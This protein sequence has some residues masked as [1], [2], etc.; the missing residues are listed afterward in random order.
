MKDY[1]VL[2]LTAR[3]KSDQTLEQVKDLL[4]QQI[5]FIKQGNFDESLI[6]ATVD[7]AKFSFL[8]GLNNNGNRTYRLL[9]PFV[10]SKTKTWP[11]EVSALDDM[12]KLTKKDIVDFANKWLVIIMYVFTK[13]RRRQINC[14]KSASHRSLLSK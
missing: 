5:N 6:R 10:V 4:L 12:S 13:K 3:N 2:F 14:K 7:N 8:D 11:A 9:N 1:S